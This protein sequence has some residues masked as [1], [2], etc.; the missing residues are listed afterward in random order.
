M[1][2][3]EG[4]EADA[5]PN[6]ERVLSPEAVRRTEA[7]RSPWAAAGSRSETARA[8]QQPDPHAAAEAAPR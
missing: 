1:R 3:A 6:R 8:Q 5:R 2:D 7:K 4:A